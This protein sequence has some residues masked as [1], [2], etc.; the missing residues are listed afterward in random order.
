MIAVRSGIMSALASVLP[1]QPLSLEAIT[2]TGRLVARPSRKADR[3]AERTALRALAEA[4]PQGESRILKCLATLGV[5]LCRAGTAGVSVL[6]D[7]PDGEIFRWHALAGEL[8]QYEGGT[9]PRNFSPCGSCL[10]AGKP[11]LY[12][13][14]ARRFTY[15][16]QLDTPIVEGLVIP[17]YVAGTA[18]ATIWI[19]SHHRDRGFDAEDVRIM[20]SLG[21]FAGAA[22]DP[23]NRATSL[24]RCESRPELDRETV[25]AGYIRRIARHDQ[26]AL[27]ALFHEASPLVFSTALRIVGFPADADEVAGDV[28]ARVW[29][30]AYLY[31]DL[32]GHPVG[33]VLTITRNLSFDRLRTRAPEI[34]SPEALRVECSSAADPE[35]SW[36]SAQQRSLLREA[37]AG[38]PSEQRRAIELAYLSGLSHA[39]IAQLLGEPLGTIKTRI[40]LGL[41]RLRSSLAA[42]A[43]RSARKAQ[44][45]L[46]DI[47]LTRR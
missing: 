4:L 37:L 15:F 47:C 2:V 42:A 29:N 19:V 11:M 6:E 20:T 13:Y 8:A 39:D 32:R 28:F 17:V 36:S 38:L 22:L 14:P 43:G 44:V 21:N 35:S 34:Q 46:K 30:S 45:V 40:R 26:S 3:R 10:D 16:A 27:S 12:E 18:A 9:T 23:G 25:W 1:A 5:S 7:S 24:E 31:N 33:W 41:I